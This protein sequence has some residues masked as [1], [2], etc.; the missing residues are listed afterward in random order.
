MSADDEVIEEYAQPVQLRVRTRLNVRAAPT[1]AA[2]LMMRR[3]PGDVLRADRLL[4]AES[5]LDNANWYRLEPAG[6]YVWGG[7]VERELPLPQLAASAAPLNVS[8]RP[9]GTIRP[10]SVAELMQHY[11]PFTFTENRDGSIN[12]AVPWA[13]QHIVPFTHP[14]LAA[15]NR[16]TLQVHQLALPAFKGVFDAIEAAGPE[17]SSC[18]LT[19]AGTFV[20]RH[21]SWNPKKELSSHSFGV[22]IDINAEW[23]GYGA[24]PKESG[25]RGS[26]LALVPYF[27]HFGFAWGGHFSGGSV[28][29]MHFELANF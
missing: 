26:V 12:I 25:L 3:Q 8:R 29:G 5:Y 17:I 13:A 1:T 10:R 4:H 19:C 28:D 14:L 11:G 21:I 7:G 24:R 2:A 15:I 16:N 22:A 23:N 18:I 27:N 6:H 9:D 20:P